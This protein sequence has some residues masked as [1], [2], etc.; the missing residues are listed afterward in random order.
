MSFI[1][2]ADIVACN[3]EHLQEL[4]FLCILQTETWNGLAV[5]KK[6]PGTLSLMQQQFY[7]IQFLSTLEMQENVL[8]SHLLLHC[9]SSVLSIGGLSSDHKYWLWKDCEKLSH[10]PKFTHLNTDKNCTLELIPT[11]KKNCK[12]QLLS[13]SVIC[14]C[15]R[16]PWLPES[17]Y[18]I[19]KGIFFPACA[20]LEDLGTPCPF[21]RQTDPLWQ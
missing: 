9:K 4:G 11:N 21:T 7:F 18:P 14:C 3:L 17:C 2:G 12:R 1:L 6:N 20:F 8:V 13:P 15:K 10:P 5:Y 19:R 16:L